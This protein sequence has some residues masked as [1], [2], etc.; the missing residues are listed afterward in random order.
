MRFNIIIASLAVMVLSL[1]SCKLGQKYV[2]P[3][4]PLPE[5]LGVTATTDT[6]SIA[7][8]GWWDIYTDTILQ[9]LIKQTME[10]NKDLRIAD[11]RIKELAARKR[12]EFAGIFPE[13]NGSLYT[14]KEGLNYGGD[15]FKNDPEYG[16]KAAMSWELD[17]WGNKRWA[18]ERGKAEFMSG[19]ENRRA[20]TMSLVADVAQAYYEL[21]ALDHELAI[22]KQTLDARRESV[23]LAKLRFEGGL[24]SET[25]YQQAQVE[26]ARTATRVPVL[27]RDIAMKEN[28]ISFIAGEFPSGIERSSRID[29]RLPEE[30]PVGIPSTLLERRPDIRAAEQKLI[31]ANAAV[32][33]AYTNR[34]PRLALTGQLG[35]ESDE[36]SSLFKSPMHFLSASLLGPL[37][38][39]GRRQST[40]RAQQAV[41]EQECY[42]YEKVVLNAFKEVRDA[43]VAYNKARDIYETMAQLVH[44]SKT[45][46]DLAQLQYINGVI[47]YIDVLDAQRSYFDA[48]VGLSNAALYKRLAMVQLYKALGGGW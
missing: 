19:I 8:L 13:I 45:N 12:I 17:L 42:A 24:T 7:D 41:Y 23:R 2:R 27:E 47:G 30:L 37:F 43:I 18:N 22:V 20:L 5:N 36:F 25:A 35:V 46:M 39:M 31:A 34:F 44:A 11:A 10:H 33:V 21:V 28:E 40:Y 29:M 6:F 4:M 48:Q 1:G 15:N 32:G 9:R 14:Q 3:D 38:D 26:Y 16:L